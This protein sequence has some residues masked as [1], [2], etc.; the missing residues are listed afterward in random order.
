MPVGVSAV[1]GHRRMIRGNS[2]RDRDRPC[3]DLGREILIKVDLAAA[4][5][6]RAHCP[7]AQLLPRRQVGCPPRGRDQ[8][9][10]VGLAVPGTDLENAACSRHLRDQTLGQDLDAFFTG[11]A[12]GTGTRSRT[13]TVSARGPTLLNTGVPAR[14]CV[15]GSPRT[16]GVAA[17]L[18]VVAARSGQLSTPHAAVPGHRYQ[19]PSLQ[20]DRG[21][22]VRVVLHHAIGTTV[23]DPLQDLQLTGINRGGTIHHR[24]SGPR[25][26]RVRALV[27]HSGRGDGGTA[28]KSASWQPLVLRQQQQRH[29]AWNRG[30]G[31]GGA[32]S[33]RTARTRFLAFTADRPGHLA[34][35]GP[36]SGWEGAGKLIR[37]LAGASDEDTMRR[38][39]DEIASIARSADDD[40]RAEMA[41]ELVNYGRS[42]P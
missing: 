4:R 17:V 20:R 10:V 24:I 1:A 40:E 37:T 3:P 28:D 34:A 29:L 15:P 26:K 5:P 13:V 27:P 16:F 9:L 19:P 7:D 39:I 41:R 32:V 11:R 33:V 25:T 23:S 14:C 31:R 21:R 38:I 35:G 6:V 2:L 22:L 12:A 18:K 36:G 42:I 30:P 8:L